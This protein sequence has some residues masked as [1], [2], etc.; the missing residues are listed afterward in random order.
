M[1]KRIVK[2]TFREETVAV[3]IGEVFEQSKNRIRAFP[4]CRHMEL[5]QHTGTPHILFTLSM[6]DDEAALEMYRQS[7]LFRSTWAQTKALFAAP[8]E[9]WSVRVA[10]AG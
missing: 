5:L 2:M 7:E 3:F 8:A 10:D 4:G 6:W 1:I 9:A